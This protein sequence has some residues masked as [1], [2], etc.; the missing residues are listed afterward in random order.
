MIADLTDPRS[1][2]QELARIVPILPSVA[3]QP[4]IHESQQPWGMFPDL[5]RYPWMLEPYRYGS[6]E[7]L[8]EAL[9]QDVILP[10]E[11]KAKDLTEGR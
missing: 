2:P 8:L 4:I 6:T 7:G 1:V 5:K 11:T 10:A 9:E 3:V